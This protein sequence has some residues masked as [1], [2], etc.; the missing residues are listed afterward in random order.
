MVLGVAFAT[1][2][3]AAAQTAEPPQSG[4]T[5]PATTTVNGDTGLWFV[6]TAE[7]LADRKWS[8]SFFRQNMDFGQGFTDV[9]HFPI[10][11]AV[12]LGNRVELFGSFETITRIDR[13][14]R[15]VFFAASG[16]VKDSANG[17]VVNEYPLVRDGWIGNRIGDLRIGLKFNIASEADNKAAAFAIRAG[18][19]IPTGDD[20][21]GASTGKPDYYVDA[22]VSKQLRVFELSGF[23][24]VI[25]RGNP[26]GFDLSS[27]LRYGA[28]AGFPATSKLRF[29]L[30]F[31]GE[32]YFDS[33][34][35]APAGFTAID[36]SV[37]PLS[38]PNASPLWGV[39]GVTYQ[40]DSGF[41]LGAGA[42]WSAGT[43]PRNGALFCSAGTATCPSSFGSGIGDRL[44]LQVRLGYHPGARK[45]VA[46]V[47]PPPPPVRNDPPPPANR[48]PTV[49]AACDPCTVEV[50]RV[51][52]VTADAQ[53]PDG[54]PLT[55]RWSANTGSFTSP[56]NRQTPWTAPNTPGTVPVTVTVTDSRGANA[57]ASVNIQVV[58]PQPKEYVFEDVHFDFDRYTLRTDALRVL[59]EAV[60]AMQA[61]SSLRLTIE[62]HT[63]NIGT[64]EYNLALGERRATAVREYL[65]SR[66][67]SGDRLTVVSYGE[68]RPKFDNSREETRRMNRRAAL[69]VRLQ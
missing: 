56:T 69:V 43:S 64:T 23:G 18:L 53:D 4:E 61:D 49:T 5:R 68:E 27:G 19:K 32:R 10:T 38:T 22:I 48:A 6:P 21:R 47:P 29:T 40:A 51:S 63:C 39:F 8:I 30:E 15:P 26:D 31:H 59:D 37:A 28:G 34:V 24:G 52:T 25:V 17:G 3:T 67:I 20:D 41:F 2:G 13:D 60:T 7:V 12:G 9:T 45:Y 66:G 14:A 46:P 36:N 62:G 11:G 65:A 35:G 1:A 44:G 33:T 16:A 42:N 58:Q 57:T 50:G 55:Y 54:D